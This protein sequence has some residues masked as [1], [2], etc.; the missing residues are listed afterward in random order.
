MKVT[1]EVIA[2]ITN[3][4]ASMEY[5]EL[6]ITVAEKGSFV[7][8]EISEKF[9]VNKESLAMLESHPRKL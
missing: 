6:K 2:M 4:L 7:E 8:M 1:P 3:A 9:H 5:G